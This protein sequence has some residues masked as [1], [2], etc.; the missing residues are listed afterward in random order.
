MEHFKEF[1]G[2]K[3]NVYDL[4]IKK[5]Y[6]K[7][8]N[9]GALQ[10][11]IN[12]CVPFPYIFVINYELAFRRKELLD[13]EHFTL[14]LDESSLIQNENAKRSKFILKLKPDNVILLSGT[15]TGGKYEKL[16][17]QM[18]L[19]GW[20]ISKKCSI[21]STLIITMRIMKVFH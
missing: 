12:N 17:S 21:T 3:Y 7:L 13:L 9:Q 6:E 10:N 1:Y 5:H 15:P 19:L 4:T 18:K 16:W 14:M 11:A 20:N 8:C 2:D